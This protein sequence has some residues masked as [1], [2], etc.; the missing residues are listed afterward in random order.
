MGDGQA[1]ETCEESRQYVAGHETGLAG[2]RDA[3]VGPAESS[4]RRRI[5]V[6]VHVERSRQAEGPRRKPTRY[7]R[8]RDAGDG[9]D[10]HVSPNTPDCGGDVGRQKLGPA[11]DDNVGLF[12]LLSEQVF[13]LGTE[14]RRSAVDALQSK[15]VDHNG[16]RQQLHE[17]GP[18]LCQW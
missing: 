11:E 3:S 16:I 18:P 7:A 12:E 9:D 2:E 14:T 6:V 8:P 5:G 17:L 4:L 15:W 13:D 1:S 10:R